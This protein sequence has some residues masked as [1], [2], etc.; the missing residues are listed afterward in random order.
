[1]RTYLGVGNSCVV[2]VAT[3]SSLW[4]NKKAGHPRL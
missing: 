3:R 1:M 4:S 2:Y